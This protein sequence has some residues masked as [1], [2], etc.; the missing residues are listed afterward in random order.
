M[1]QRAKAHV[2]AS[3]DLASRIL[4]AVP[5]RSTAALVMSSAAPPRYRDRIVK[6]LGH[7]GFVGSRPSSAVF[8]DQV[9]C[10]IEDADLKQGQLI[11]Y[12]IGP[13]KKPG[14][15][16]AIH[17]VPIINGVP[18]GE[19]VEK[20]SSFDLDQEARNEEKRWCQK[21]QQDHDLESATQKMA[22]T[23]LTSSATAAGKAGN[24]AGSAFGSLWEAY[25]P[26]RLMYFGWGNLDEL[27]RDDLPLA[28]LLS[29]PVCTL[30]LGVDQLPMYRAITRQ[31]SVY[32]SYEGAGE[33]FKPTL[34]VA[35][36]AA[37]RHGAGEQGSP[38][39]ALNQYSLVTA[40][41]QLKA[42]MTMG[43]Y[44][45]LLLYAYR[46]AESAPLLLERGRTYEEQPHSV[47]AQWERKVM[48][49]GEEA[50]HLTS[51]YNLV[52]GLIGGERVLLTGELDGV[53]DDQQPL[54]VTTSPLGSVQDE[55]RLLERWTQSYL[56]AVPRLLRASFQKGMA[57]DN[58]S[59]FAPSNV[60]ITP[61][62]ELP[63]EA[64]LKERGFA[65]VAAL[66]RMLKGCVR[67][68]EYYQVMI[69]QGRVTVSRLL[70]PQRRPSATR[71]TFVSE[72]D[73]R[74][75]AEMVRMQQPKAP[76][77]VPVAAAAAAA[78]HP[79]PKGAAIPQ[80][81]AVA[82]AQSSASVK[83]AVAPTS[84][85]PPSSSAPVASKP[86]APVIAAIS[87]PAS[88]KL[89]PAAAAHASA[90]VSSG[91]GQ[92]AAQVS[93]P[94]PTLPPGGI[95]PSSSPPSVV[96]SG[97]PKAS[98]SS[99]VPAAANPALQ[100]EGLN[101][102][103]RV[104]L[105]VDPRVSGNARLK[106]AALAAGVHVISLATGEEAARWLRGPGRA[107]DASRIR[108]ITSHALTAT[109]S[110]EQLER[111][112]VSSP[113]LAAL[114]EIQ[115][116]VRVLIYCAHSYPSAQVFVQRYISS[117]VQHQLAVTMTDTVA[118]EFVCFA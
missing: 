81:P 115:A 46:P 15:T 102:G 83:P 88:L 97:A 89:Q 12:S 111:C 67:V 99:S 70:D 34:L 1:G 58:P 78:T 76:A 113:V 25:A 79:A 98:S 106:A 84:T 39:A 17:I 66:I 109:D 110:P 7:M 55:Q 43:E 118:H 47:G 90:P 11:E 19:R 96:N 22:Q 30:G 42:L 24:A 27:R 92:A 18:M 40:R 29:G 54:E 75:M 59:V 5:G 61:I 32:P 37:M 72:K 4:P 77:S 53:D 116:A 6:W 71:D 41:K 45:S 36:L 13:G 108:I 74:D 44:G 60:D 73:L 35:L 31:F 93:R 85:I 114:R 56:C 51:V 62:S 117:G 107:V 87:S 3:H 14:Q 63:V 52:T 28:H 48:I 86:A 16:V 105:Y 103:A 50:E 33:E 57:Q 95:A 80:Q 94:L 8:P 82:V 23:K 65:R 100:V 26:R 38:E 2:F 49:K 9:L 21:Q 91:G 20:R 101:P 64:H 10:N 112:G 68:G 104:L 69:L